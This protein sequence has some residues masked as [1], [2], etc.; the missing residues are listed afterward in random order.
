MRSVAEQARSDEEYMALALEEAALAADRDEVPVGAVLVDC[1]GTVLTKGRN[2]REELADPTAH[3]EMEALR[4]DST[5]SGNWRREDTTLYVTLE[6]CPMCMGALVLA[7]VRRVVFGATDPKGGAA[8][9]LYELGTDSRLNHQIEVT[10]GVLAERC[11]QQLK[12]FFRE[13]RAQRAVDKK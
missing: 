6:P 2:R 11:S 7:R 12:L 5:N 1:D 10:G 8:V 9:S 13:L 3:A 4:G